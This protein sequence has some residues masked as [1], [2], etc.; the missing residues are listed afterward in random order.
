MMIKE[1]TIYTDG[2]CEPNPGIGGWAAIVFDESKDQRR[3]LVGNAL[4]TTNNRME[5]QAVIRGLSIIEMPSRITIYTDSKYVFSGIGNWAKG[6][7]TSHIGWVVS[8]MKNDWRKS[9]RSKVSNIDLWT[10]LI[11]EV[12]RH[13]IITMKHIR[14]HCGNV[15]NEECDALAVEARLRLKC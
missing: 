12:R 8:W 14:G 9:D 6:A 13:D 10:N 3:E 5:M 7:P 15:F 1:Y 4:D 11:R 2:A